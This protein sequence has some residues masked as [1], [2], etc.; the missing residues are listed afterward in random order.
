[1][2]MPRSPR[3]VPGA[4][5]AGFVAPIVCRTSSTL[6]GPRTA[7]ATTGL[8]V[9][10]CHQ[11]GEERPLHVGLVVPVGQRLVDLHQLHAHQLQPAPLQPRNDLS[12]QSPLQPVRLDEDQCCLDVR[13]NV[14]PTYPRHT[15]GSRYPETPRPTASALPAHPSRS[16]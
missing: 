7:S 9:M 1:M 4:A 5:A 3:T 15:G 11:S 13:Q 10:N 12:G 16:P 2:S 14:P 8:E 6:F